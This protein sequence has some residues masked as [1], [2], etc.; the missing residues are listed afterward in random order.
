[1]NKTNKSLKEWNAI[2]EAL[3]TGLQTII[4]RKNPT[5]AEGFL[6]YPTFNYAL[7]DEYL[8]NFKKEFHTFVEENS[9]IIIDKD[10]EIIEIKFYAKVEKVLEISPQK[11]R[12]INNYHIW[13]N[14]HVKDYLSNK[15]GYIWFLKIYK[16]K[17][18]I[19]VDK[20]RGMRFI[21]LKNEISLVNK[22]PVIGEK[23]YSN[24][25]KVFKNK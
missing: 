18:N 17:E 20:H 2:V 9:L 23:E 25:R 13:N 6:L 5:N 21:N 1:M 3:G 16:L 11:L 19:I 24:I 8:K 14:N 12:S 15:K 22:V 10:R 4:I 7:K